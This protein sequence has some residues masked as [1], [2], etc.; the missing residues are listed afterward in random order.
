MSGSAGISRQVL[1]FHLVLYRTLLRSA[2]CHIPAAQGSRRAWELFFL[3]CGAL[4]KE[5]APLSRF[6]L[7]RC[8]SGSDR[9]RQSTPS[10]VVREQIPFSLA[11]EPRCIFTSSMLP[12][13]LPVFFTSTFPSFATSRL[14]SLRTQRRPTKKRSRLFERFHRRR[15]CRTSLTLLYH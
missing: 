7:H 4:I 14:I 13:S 6:F 5:I 11:Q 1:Q 15:T 12:I 8:R 3:H 10:I 2:S 9:C